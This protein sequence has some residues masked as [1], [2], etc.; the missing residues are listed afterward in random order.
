M[1]VQFDRKMSDLKIGFI[2]SFAQELAKHSM[3]V[4]DIS[5]PIVIE[6]FDCVNE[7]YDLIFGAGLYEIIP[8]DILNVPKFGMLFFHATPLPEGKGNAP[9]FWTV[10]NKRPNITV[11][12]F[13][14]NNSIDA[15]PIACQSNVAIEETDNY[16]ILYKK[17]WQGVLDCLEAAL[18]DISQGVL[19]FREQTGV[20]SFTAKRS[21]SDSQID[22]NMKLIDLW[23]H[24]RCCDNENFP[25]FFELNGKKVYL[26]H[27]VKDD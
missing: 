26:Y 25:A 17:Q 2:G 16:P 9:I 22:P 21:P 20:S 3:K 19:V 12:C 5:D 8:E 11:S 7:T 23:D 15:G 6:S 10:S 4:S 27:K 24:I 14:P 1:I 18:D 13:R